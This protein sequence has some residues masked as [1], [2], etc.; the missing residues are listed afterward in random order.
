VHFIPPKKKNKKAEDLALLFLRE[1]WRLHGILGDI[2]QIRTP[3]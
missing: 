1:S 2:I 3:G